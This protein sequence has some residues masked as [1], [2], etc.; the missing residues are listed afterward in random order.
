VTVTH[1]PAPAAA[2]GR[3]NQAGQESDRYLI[4]NSIVADEMRRLA[5]LDS[6]ICRNWAHFETLNFT[7]AAGSSPTKNS[8][9]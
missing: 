8:T 1:D 7:V 3:K 4:H 6:R 2:G 5:V 9:R